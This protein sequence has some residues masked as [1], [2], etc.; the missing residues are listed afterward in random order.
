MS[1]ELS[2]FHTRPSLLLRV[3]DKSDAA[4]WR[5]FVDLYAPLIRCYCRRCQLQD[6]EA[7]DVAQEVFLAVSKCVENWHYDTDRGRFRDWLGTVTRNAI[8]KFRKKEGRANRLN[9]CQVADGV[10]ENEPGQSSDPIWEEEFTRRVLQ[11][12]LEGI[13]PTF[14]AATW[15]AFELA[16]K[17]MRP[18]KEVA[19]EL[20]MSVANVYHCKSRVLKRLRQRLEELTG[21]SILAS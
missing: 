7:A 13:R 4:A 5:A 6:E 3:R 11:V 17:A 12:A 20:K 2:Q 19:E 14:D 10:L 1:D 15:Q 9:S 18:E 21:D 8:I 16:W